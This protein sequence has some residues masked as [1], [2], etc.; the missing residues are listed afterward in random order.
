MARADPDAG[1][2]VAK[3]VDARRVPRVRGFLGS[4]TLLPYFYRMAYG[5]GASA[6]A[7]RFALGHVPMWLAVLVLPSVVTAYELLDSLVSPNGTFWSLAY[8]Q[9]DFLA[10]LQIASVTGIWGIVFVLVL[11]PSA[12][13]IAWHTRA[14]TPLIPAAATLLLVFG[15]GIAPEPA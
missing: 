15:F 12:I 11:V 10:A 13:A 14:L 3:L 8:S 6:L 5:E 4:F 2:S 1:H 7:A 9:A